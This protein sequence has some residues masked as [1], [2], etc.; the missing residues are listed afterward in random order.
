MHTVKAITCGTAKSM[1]I[2]YSIEHTM[3]MEP[4]S[5]SLLNLLH[6]TNFD[7]IA[8]WF[9]ILTCLLVFYEL[10]VFVD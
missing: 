5:I 2:G 3:L 7:H 10:D 4:L 6:L 1:L 9:S 8:L